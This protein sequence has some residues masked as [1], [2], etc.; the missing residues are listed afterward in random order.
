MPDTAEFKAFAAPA[1]IN[2]FLHVTG[3]RADGY[4]QLQT[5][6]CLLDFHD[7][8]HLRSTADGNISRIDGNPLVAAE[9]DLSVRAARLLQQHTGCRQGVAIRVEKRI[10]L[11]GGLGGGSSDAASI[12]LALNRLWQL[13]LSRAELQKLA[14]TLG[15]DV[16][17]FIFGQN[18]WADGVG[19]QLQPIA[20]EPRYYLVITPD[21]HV[22]TAEI[23]ASGELTRNTI[24]TTIAAFSGNENSGQP[25]CNDLEA[26]VCARHPVI[27][28][29]MAWLSQFSPA[30]MSGSGA[31]I[32]AG[33][34]SAHAAR[35]ALA[36]L[37]P[38]MNGTRLT[39]FVAASLARHPHYALAG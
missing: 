13:R 36:Q 19:E 34:A 9:H 28:H 1:K 5:V 7:T 11:G 14:L 35:S 18:A 32:F 2:L 31:S 39:G 8:L 25:F 17:F 6:F 27:A 29:C 16:P 21:L 37:P 10:P 22:S 15:A 23:F 33:F 30:R 24:P 20:L 26:V 3:R 12:L 38:E 4:H